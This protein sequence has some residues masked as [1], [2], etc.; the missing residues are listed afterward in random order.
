MAANFVYHYPYNTSRDVQHAV[1][2]YVA[3][4][5]TSPPKEVVLRIFMALK[6]PFLTARFETANLGSDNKH[7]NHYTYE[8]V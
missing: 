2:Y 1:K 7:D 5:F 4:G 6:N 8:K 3:D